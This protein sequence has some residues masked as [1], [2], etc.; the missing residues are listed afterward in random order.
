MK[1]ER[2]PVQVLLNLRNL[3]FKYACILPYHM[4][5]QFDPKRVHKIA[6]IRGKVL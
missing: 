2:L 6:F 3:I 5:S 4:L 1:K